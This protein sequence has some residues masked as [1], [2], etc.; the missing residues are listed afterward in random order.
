MNSVQGT[1]IISQKITWH[2]PWADAVFPG[3]CQNQLTLVCAFVQK[4]AFLFVVLKIGRGGP[5]APPP[6]TLM[7]VAGLAA[8]KH[9]CNIFPLCRALQLKA[10]MPTVND[11]A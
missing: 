9:L 2:P 3:I 6:T 4:I 1:E 8:K 11:A 10:P 5:T 7:V